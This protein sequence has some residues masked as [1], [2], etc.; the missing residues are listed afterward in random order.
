MATKASVGQ[1]AWTV[2]DLA[3]DTSWIVTLDDAAARDMADAVRAAYV[4]DKPLFDYRR[5]DFDLGR[6]GAAVARGVKEA[7]D[8]RG[9]AILRGLPR[10]WLTEHEFEVMTWALGLHTGVAR[11]QGKT[12]QFI[13]RVRNE[14]TTYRSAGGRGYSSG[15]KLDFHV[16]GADL[17]FLT[18]FNDAKSGGESMVTSSVAAHGV[19]AAE[20]PELASLLREEPL[21]FSR[22]KEEAPDEG[23]FYT[24][25]VWDEA[26]GLLY[27]KWNRNRVIS[28]QSIE[29]VPK[30]TARQHEAI[31]LLDE[32]LARPALMYRM[33]LRP[34]DMQILNNHTMLHSRTDFADHDDP[35]HKRCLF[36][37][38][39]SPPDWPDLPESWRP[40]YRSIEAGTVRG[41]IIGQSYDDTRR[42]WEHRQA[43][44]LGMRITDRH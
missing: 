22:Q 31:D 39:L 41:G 29:G 28:A 24:N 15:A 27:G 23:A 6:A 20:R 38:W 37:L 34:G 11:P 14:G 12:S 2:E 42:D 7:K 44:E 1:A 13:A 35:G 19:L 18:C 10:A 5:G 21:Y 16:D 26:G 4:P 17:V 43:A 8:G 40:F 32:I 36:R 3:A 30:L 9:F 25:P 33:Y